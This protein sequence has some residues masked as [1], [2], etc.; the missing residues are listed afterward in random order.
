MTNNRT[1][2]VLNASHNKID[3]AAVIQLRH[4]LSNNYALRSL[5]LHGNPLNDEAI[6]EIFKINTHNLRLIKVPQIKDQDLKSSIDTRIK[7]LNAGRKANNHIE[8]F[9]W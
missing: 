4:A 1:L 3:D 8:W 5:R 7:R 2:Q 9:S 6:E